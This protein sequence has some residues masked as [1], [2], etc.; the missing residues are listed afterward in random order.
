MYMFGER[1]R[2]DGVRVRDGERAIFI[3]FLVAPHGVMILK[4][5]GVIK[6]VRSHHV[7]WVMNGS[8]LSVLV[9][10]VLPT[11]RVF[12]LDR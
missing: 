7:S 2:R 10:D 12:W 6:F 4:W 5:F 3:D 1:E 11:G 9:T 8:I